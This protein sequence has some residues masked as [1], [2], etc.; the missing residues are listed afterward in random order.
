LLSAAVTVLLLYL[1]LLLLLMLRLTS[2]AA[3]CSC[4]VVSANSGCLAMAVSICCRK[5]CR[6]Q[7][8]QAHTAQHSNQSL[9]AI[10]SIDPV[11]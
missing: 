1:L 9:Q 3:S 10:G 11:P 5:P 2:V 8:G 4:G 7:H 6:Q